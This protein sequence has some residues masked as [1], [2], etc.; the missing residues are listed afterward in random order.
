MVLQS[1]IVESF[2]GE[3]QPT[4]SDSDI[5]GRPP[6]AGEVA[7]FVIPLANEVKNQTLSLMTY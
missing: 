6:S 3:Y 4:S 7:M 1:G 2:R 5:N